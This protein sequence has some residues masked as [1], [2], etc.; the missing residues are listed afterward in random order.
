MAVRYTAE[1]LLYLRE[2]P[3][4]V[5]P[6]NLPPAEEWMGYVSRTHCAANSKLVLRILLD[7]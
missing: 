4:C 1:F 3:L 5:K 7:A 6:L 2:S